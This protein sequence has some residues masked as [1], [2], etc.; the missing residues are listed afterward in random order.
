MIRR[1]LAFSANRLL[2]MK[3]QSPD[4]IPTSMPD[5]PNP[6]FRI[7]ERLDDMEQ[8]M[9]ECVIDLRRSVELLADTV[10]E[11]NRRIERLESSDQ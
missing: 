5:F 9:S 11:L 6:D 3:T 1:L 10:G 8:S 7:I 4:V 2:G